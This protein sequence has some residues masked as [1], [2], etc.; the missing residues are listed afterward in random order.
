MSAQAKKI[1]IVDDDRFLLDMYAVKFKGAG[2]DVNLSSSGSDALEKITHG[3]IPDII[4]LDIVMPEMTGIELLE[5]LHKESNVKDSVIVVLSNQEKSEETD[6]IKK[7]GVDGYIIKARTI[8]S[9]VL[10]MVS[11]IFAKKHEQY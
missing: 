10:D 8:P 5:H 7:L 3:F 6:E 4:L 1:L 2:F 9:E 11:N